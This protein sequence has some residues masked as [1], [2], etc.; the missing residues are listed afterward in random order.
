MIAIYFVKREG[1]MRPLWGRKIN[2]NAFSIDI[3]LLWSPLNHKSIFKKD[4]GEI[5]VRRK[6]K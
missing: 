4:P 1:N 2:N 6:K 3:G 5:P